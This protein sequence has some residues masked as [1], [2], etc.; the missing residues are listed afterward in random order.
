MGAESTAE[1]VAKSA[2]NGVLDAFPFERMALAEIGAADAP[3]IVEGDLI[4]SMMFIV[5][6]SLQGWMTMLYVRRLLAKRSLLSQTP[7]NFDAL[8]EPLIVDATPVS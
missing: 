2:G 7:I 1:S 6:V 4:R 5:A 8:T 3:R